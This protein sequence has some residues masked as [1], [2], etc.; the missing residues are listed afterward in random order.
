MQGPAAYLQSQ[1]PCQLNACQQLSLAHHHRTD[2]H[3]AALQGGRRL[4]LGNNIC[5]GGTY[6]AMQVQ[7][8]SVECNATAESS[9]AQIS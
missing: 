3:I 6:S 4:Q 2:G 9:S 7:K 5:G 8:C 1:V